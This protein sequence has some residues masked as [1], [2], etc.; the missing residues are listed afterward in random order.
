MPL[1]WSTYPTT[2]DPSRRWIVTAQEMNPSRRVFFTSS[3]RPGTFL[4]TL[5]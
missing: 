5:D 1:R 3:T 2:I 4:V